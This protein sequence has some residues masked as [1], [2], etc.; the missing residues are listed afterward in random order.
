MD[1]KNK[2]E[3][4]DLVDRLII[5]YTQSL[6]EQIMQMLTESDKDKTQCLMAIDTLKHEIFKQETERDTKLEKKLLDSIDKRFEGEDKR[7]ATAIGTAISAHAGDDS[8][9]KNKLSWSVIISI[10]LGILTPFAIVMY[11]N[12]QGLWELKVDFNAFRAAHDA[13]E[14]IDTNKFGQNRDGRLSVASESSMIASETRTS[15]GSAT[16]ASGS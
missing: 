7:Q 16:T 15:S 2:Q 8:G 9:K 14:N 13:R 6:R 1:S 11:D 3:I 5:K 4:N 10:I 12:Y